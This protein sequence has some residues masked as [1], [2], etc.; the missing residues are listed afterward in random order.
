MYKNIKKVRKK[1]IF[2]KHRQN[3]FK[4]NDMN[5]HV[6]RSIHCHQ[7][8]EIFDATHLEILLIWIVFIKRV[9]LYRSHYA[10]SMKEVMWLLLHS[11][12]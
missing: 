5:H 9:K 6:M 12:C 7:Y 8:N 10:F 1:T 2:N 11:I 3:V 4:I